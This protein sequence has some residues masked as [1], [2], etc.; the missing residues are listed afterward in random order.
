MSL[1]IW[2]AVSVTAGL[3]LASNT[4]SIEVM[5]LGFQSTMPPGSKLESEGVNSPEGSTMSHDTTSAEVPEGFEPLS[6]VRIAEKSGSIGKKSYVIGGAKS[7]LPA[8]HNISM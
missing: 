7:G 8:P 4:R 6:S 3:P 5:V 2:E 1:V